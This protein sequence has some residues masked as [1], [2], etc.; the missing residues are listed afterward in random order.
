MTNFITDL[1]SAVCG[2]FRGAR[3]GW[4]SGWKR[5][6]TDK[7]IAEFYSNLQDNDEL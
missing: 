7:E 5:R 2:L 3:L 6:R 4:L 1:R